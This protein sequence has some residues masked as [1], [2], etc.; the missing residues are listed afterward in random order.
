MKLLIAA[1]ALASVVGVVAA[2][3]LAGF[4]EPGDRDPEGKNLRQGAETAAVAAAD[5]TGGAAAAAGGAGRRPQV[6]TS[7]VCDGKTDTGIRNCNGREHCL[8]T[9]YDNPSWDTNSRGHAARCI[10]ECKSR[11]PAPRIMDTTAGKFIEVVGNGKC[12][13]FSHLRAWGDCGGGGHIYMFSSKGYDT[14]YEYFN[15]DGFSTKE[16]CAR[17][18]AF[19]DED[20]RAGGRGVSISYSSATGNCICD[21][22]RAGQVS[23]VEEE[24]GYE[25]WGMLP[26]VC[27]GH[28]VDCMVSP[29]CGSEAPD[30]DAASSG[31]RLSASTGAAGNGHVIHVTVDGEAVRAEVA[32]A[33]ARALGG[34]DNF[35]ALVNPSNAT[36]QHAQLLVLDKDQ[37]EYDSGWLDHR[38]GPFIV[39]NAF[40]HGYPEIKYRVT[41]P[42]LAAGAVCQVQGVHDGADDG[43]APW[44]GECVLPADRPV[45]SDACLDAA[46]EVSLFALPDSHF[47]LGATG[48]GGDCPD[49]AL[50]AGRDGKR[51]SKR[52]VRF[53]P[54]AAAGVP[55]RVVWT[56]PLRAVLAAEARAPDPAALPFDVTANS[57][58][59]HAA[60]IWRLLGLPEDAA[61][62]DF[63]VENIV[64]RRAGGEAVARRLA[65]G[66]PAVA[67]AGSHRDII[68]K[69]VYSQMEL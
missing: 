46:Y 25:C 5:G 69:V 21:T 30:C 47:R 65:E 66:D 50:F 63:I 39:Q 61:L 60:A 58:L 55:A 41:C 38:D 64:A 24:E 1:L 27:E 31:R 17:S 29:V 22:G 9:C 57:C 23:G 40:D 13:A 20:E 4:D 33:L 67:G 3:P 2:A 59:H 18:C 6:F 52:R 43:A 28:Q 16:S 68:K 44:F 42:A 37:M 26:N 15:E 32:D 45:A 62:A 35:Q 14:V 54:A 53:P 49:V 34:G 19:Y 56:A 7:D 36:T 48:P 8:A 11:Y 51:V 10:Y 12:K